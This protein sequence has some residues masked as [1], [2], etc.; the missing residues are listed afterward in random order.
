MMTKNEQEIVGCCKY[1]G[2]TVCYWSSG[3]RKQSSKDQ[4]QIILTLS[5]MI[6]ELILSVDWGNTDTSIGIPQIASYA[7]TRQVI[8]YISTGMWSGLMIIVC[9]S[10]ILLDT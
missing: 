3:T 10:F 2:W 4:N 1:F 7:V 6:K 9:S 5:P 8:D